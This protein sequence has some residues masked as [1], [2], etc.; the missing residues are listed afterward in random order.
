[1][2]V[3]D[4]GAV[5][6]GGDSP[7]GVAVLRGSRLPVGVAVL[8]HGAAGLLGVVWQVRPLL[9][10]G[11]YGEWGDGTSGDAAAWLTP[12]VGG[13]FQLR[14]LVSDDVGGVA[15]RQYAWAADE[16]TTVGFRRRG[17]SRSFGVADER[18]Q[19]DLLASARA[20]LG[21]GGYGYDD[22]YPAQYGFASVPPTAWKCNIFVA[23]RICEIGLKVP[24]LHSR[25]LLWGLPPLA[26]EWAGSTRI[27]GWAHAWGN[28]QPGWVIAHPNSLGSGHVG[29]VDF[30]GVGIAA[31]KKIVNRKY[32]DWLDGSSTYRRK[33]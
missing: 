9:R 28:P 13:V 11:A 22:D 32:E 14:A 12:L 7:G 10:T 6:L 16:D 19:L 1:M 4:V 20:H 5:S 30:D 18:W 15:V 21:L 33:E 24:A 23:H 25:L 27:E 31:G 17:D 8:P 3:A 26:N 29:I 2:T